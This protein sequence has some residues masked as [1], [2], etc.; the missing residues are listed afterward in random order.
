MA[1]DPVIDWLLEEEQPAVRYRTLTELLGRRS[2]DRDVR[3]ARADLAKRG[4]VA[5]ILARRD[6]D[7]WWDNPKRDYWPKYVATNWQML[8]LSDLGATRAIPEVRASCERWMARAPLREGGVGGNSAGKGHHCFTGNMAR[9][10]VRF[11]YG[12]DPRVRIAFE[13]LADTAN[14]RGGWSCFSYADGPSPSRTLDSWEGLSAFAVYP[15][16]RWSPAMR[17]AAARGAEYYLERELFRQGER[18]EPWFRFHWPEHYYYDL[19][20]G[21]DTLTRLGYG[22]D[23]R[24][25]PALAHLRRKRRADGRW[26]LDAVHPDGPPHYEAYFRAHP[27]ERPIP[28]EFETPGRPSKMITL[29]ALGVLGRVGAA[30]PAPRD[31]RPAGRRRPEARDRAAAPAEGQIRSS[32]RR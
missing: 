23:P 24:L 27:K 3:A 25:G 32:A 20:V 9:A 7:D 31:A 11:G 6:P 10:L 14:P 29:R 26:N 21:L 30:A 2:S 4:W 12:N 13:W 8:A 16:A 19:L 17:V 5:E 18:Y 1:R 22:G 28:L 15:R